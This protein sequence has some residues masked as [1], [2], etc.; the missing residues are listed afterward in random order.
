MEELKKALQIRE[1]F[2]KLPFDEF[3]ELLE[4]YIGET[5]PKKEKEQ[6]KYTGLLNTDFFLMWAGDKL[7]TGE[8]QLT[9]PDVRLA[10]SGFWKWYAGLSIE[11][12]E[13][14]NGKEVETYLATL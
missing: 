11:E 6:F 9:I 12:L 1:R 3:T 14:Y 5:I 4:R 2:N 13:W 10:L 7:T 8:W